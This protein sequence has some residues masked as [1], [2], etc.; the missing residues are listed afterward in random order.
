MFSMQHHSRKPPNLRAALAGV[1]V[2]VP[3]IAPLEMGLREHQTHGERDKERREARKNLG[4]EEELMLFMFEGQEL[5]GH[6][7][8]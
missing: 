5:G 8:H 6:R 2:E 4:E 1:V 7:C 3:A